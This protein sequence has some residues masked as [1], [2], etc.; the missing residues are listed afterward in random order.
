VVDNGA[1]VGLI[2]IGDL[3]RACLSETISE[4][5]VLREIAEWPHTVAA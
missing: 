3:V 1:V 4:T 5:V 2:S